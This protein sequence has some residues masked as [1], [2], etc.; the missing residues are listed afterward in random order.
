MINV[1]DPTPTHREINLAQVPL[2]FQQ[3][4]AAVASLKT[5]V[6]MM[7]NGRR[8]VSIYIR[9]GGSVL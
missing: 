5:G 4:A 3:V 8:M 6:M 2:P 1:A 9:K 7:S